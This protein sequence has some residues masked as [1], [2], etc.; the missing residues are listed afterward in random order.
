MGRPPLYGCKRCQYGWGQVAFRYFIQT[1]K[2]EKE[3][4]Y[5]KPFEGAASIY[6]H[7]FRLITKGKGRHH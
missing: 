1:P 5:R 3:N 7:M 6:V 4:R 2:A